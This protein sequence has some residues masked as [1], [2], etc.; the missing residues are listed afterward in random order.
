MSLQKK[1][2]LS[3]L[4]SAFII[5][6]LSAFLYINFIEIKKEI[7]FLE[8]TDTIRSKS[9]QLRRHEKNYFLY[10]PAKAEDESNAIYQ[11][12]TELD[13]ILNNMKPSK[14]DRTASL[15][16]LVQTYRVQF[17]RLESLVSTVSGE[18][19]KF[20]K[21]SSAYS[22]VIRLIESNFLDKPLEDVQYLQ[23]V[24]LLRSD[25][26]LITTLKEL[27]N[28]INSLRKTGENILTVS[29]ELDKTAREKVDDFI[30]ISRRAIL[31]LF[32]LFLIVGFGTILFIITNVVKRLRLIMDVV[33]KTGEGMFVHVTEP[34]HTWGGD[35]VGQLIR[36]FNFMEEQLAQREKELLRSKKLAAI[37]TLAS[38]VAHELNNPLNNIYTTAQRL[39]KKTGKESP[40]FI[41][42]GLN[43]IFSQS[44]RVKS[45]V[46]DL[47]EF[48]KGREPHHRA[49]ELRS[50]L[51]DVYKNLGNTRNTEKVKFLL[52]MHPQEIVL[53]ADPEQ[54]EQVFINLFT[55][56]IDAMSGNGDLTVIADEGNSAVKIKVSDIGEGMSTET[57]EKIF[58]PFY[59][60]KDKGTGLGLA[61]VFNI[62]QK[63][64][65]RILVESEEGKGT[66]FII[67]LPKTAQG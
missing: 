33:E 61:I 14:I 32:P 28:E 64:R 11:Y 40:E 63:H 3:F 57:L 4:V 10:A 41:H 39:L 48:A 55:N 7:V 58:E 13:E 31:I 12:L 34:A 53:Y 18:S 49:I 35:E 8:L 67:T 62:I 9:L 17:T 60:T 25:H 2:I 47:L 44:M 27:D 37:G 66:S 65:G 22:K 19:E 45:I 6:L 59:T 5:A 21:S 29:K 54:V 36:K 15:K 16:N 38:G 46:G 52:E 24:L 51:S 43:D 1:I 23:T 30:R 42:N 50:L 56:A 26:T 20:K